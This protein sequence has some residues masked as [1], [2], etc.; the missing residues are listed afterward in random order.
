MERIFTRSAWFLGLALVQVL[1]LNNIYLFGLATPFLYVYVILVLD[2]NIDRTV[3]ML[4][5]F[6]LGLLIDIFC[7]TPG[8]NAAAAVLLAFVRPELLRM[9]APREEFENFEPGIHTLGIWPF[10][11][12]VLVALLLHHAVVYLLE[13]FTFAHIGYLLLRVLCSTLLTT[14]LVMSMEFIR[15]RS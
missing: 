6:A 5:A 9:F 13:A 10:M 3:L 14:M 2:K 12:Y 4:I 11:R 1:L 8:V 7:N 15:H